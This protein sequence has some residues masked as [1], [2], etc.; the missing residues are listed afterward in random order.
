[1]PEK[2]RE[3]MPIW[4]LITQE[5]RNKL[6]DLQDELYPYIR[7]DL[8]EDP[9]PPNVRYNPKPEN[10]DEIMKLISRRPPHGV[11]YR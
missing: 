3:E 6:L 1:M 4:R 2:E 7:L 10:L 5:A 8:P 11:G 9:N